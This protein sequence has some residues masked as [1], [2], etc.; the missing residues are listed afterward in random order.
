MSS[1]DDGRLGGMTRPELDYYADGAWYDAE[2]VHIRNDIPYY[3][4][5]AAESPGPVLELACGTGR[6]TIPM[7][8]AGATVLGVDVVPAMIEQANAKLVQLDVADQERLKF[9]V[10]DMR[11][12]RL[13]ETFPTVV[14]AFNT[15]MHMTEDADLEATL[16]TAR[17]HLSDDG[18][19][20]LDMHTPHPAVAPRDDPKGRYEPQEMIEP[21]SGRRFVVTENNEYDPRHQINHMHFFYQEVDHRGRHIGEEWSR[22][23]RLRVIF[24]RELDLWLHNCGLEVVG[25]WDDWEREIAFSGQGGKRVLMARKRR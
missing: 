3:A 8:Q 25:D 19:F 7:A 12:L 5:V 17:E 13:G 15:L 14:L 4:S 18:L 2:Y 23:L 16:A 22:T 10:G 1:S 9:E 21:R 11:T 20:H 24:P 6:L